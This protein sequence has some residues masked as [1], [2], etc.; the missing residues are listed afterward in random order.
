MNR[1]FI[2]IALCFVVSGLR[3]QWKWS[4]PLQAGFRVVQNQG[5]N[6]DGGN[7]RRLPLR[8]KQTVRREVWNL[9][10]ESAG[11]SLC[12]RTDVSEIRVRYLVTGGRSMPHMPATG[13]SGVDL[14]KV[15]ADGKEQI[16]YGSYSFG[17]T[18]QF[19]YKV[20]KNRCEGDRFILY[21]PL[22]NGVKWLA[23]GVPEKAWFAF[24]PASEEKAVVVYGTSIAQGACA[25][26]PGMAWSNILNRMLDVPVVNLGFSGNGR[27]EKEVLD[28]VCEQDARVF[29]LDCMANLGDRSE[30]EVC[31]LAESAVR[32]IREKCVAPILLVEHAG[33]SNG[34]TNEK[35]F[36]TFTT[37][38]AGL[39]RAYRSLKQAGVKKVYYLS[40]EELDYDP[41]A[42]V[43]Y[44]HP[45]D[46]GMMRQAKAVGKKIIRNF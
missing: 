16:C 8:A 23:V 31:Q 36:R 20:D 39:K 32:Q 15:G 25:S 26:R 2:L 41:D 17:D 18:I 13:V 38:N 30:E 21:L 45:S 4:D 43:D 35:Q 34:E 14:Y 10:C 5:W 11:L 40:R 6:E 9:A 19:S 37:P 3:A 22:Y 33:Y 46:L 28:F 7:Y 24:E 27:L 29:I 12:F 42:W 44:V 1:F